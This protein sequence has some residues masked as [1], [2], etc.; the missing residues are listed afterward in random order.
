MALTVRAAGGEEDKTQ[1]A[2]RKKGRLWGPSSRPV[3]K[4]WGQGQ[5]SAEVARACEVCKGTNER[6]HNA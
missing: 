2:W 5:A 1:N 4:T 3:G 6:V